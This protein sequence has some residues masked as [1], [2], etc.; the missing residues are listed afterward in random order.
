MGSQLL[1]NTEINIGVYWKFRRKYG[2][3]SH[4]FSCTLC[5]ICKMNS[6]HICNLNKTNYLLIKCAV[7]ITNWIM[8]TFIVYLCFISH[9]DC[10]E[11]KKKMYKLNKKVY[12]LYPT[13]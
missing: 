6:V 2:P 1:Q 11:K 4:L 7:F 13:D 12:A 3:V 9:L 8:D 5:M 10:Q